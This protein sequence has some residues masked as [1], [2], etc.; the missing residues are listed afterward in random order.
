MSLTLDHEK[1][2]VLGRILGVSGLQGEVKIHSYTRP[3]EQIFSYDTWYLRQ[4]NSWLECQARRA[5]AGGKGLLAALS[6][7]TDRDA[8]NAVLGAEIAVFR[9]QLP[10]LMAGE[11]Y[12]ADLIGLDLIDMNGVRIGRLLEIGETG[13]NDVM[14]VEGAG[15]ILIPLVMGK[16]VRQIDLEN[17]FIQ[18]DWN[19][20]YQ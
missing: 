7:V 13:A 14:V 16:I 11:Y 9:E 20:E 6:G 3:R 2:V 1:F 19:P 4:D 15:T 18:V 10:E 8:A 17:G 5:R 12:Q